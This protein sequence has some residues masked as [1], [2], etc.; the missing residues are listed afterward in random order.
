[1]KIL[2]R[3]QDIFHRFFDSDIWYSFKKSKVT[4]VAACVTVVLM[5]AAIAAPLIAHP[6][7]RLIRHL[8]T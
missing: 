7:H 1:M 4:V 6:I 8:S 2:L 3:A 5:L